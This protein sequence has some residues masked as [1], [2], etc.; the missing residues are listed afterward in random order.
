MFVC[1]VR[2]SFRASI[3][4]IGRFSEKQVPI[5]PSPA[6]MAAE[7]KNDRER[8]LDALTSSYSCVSLLK[9]SSHLHA[10]NIS[11]E[12]LTIEFRTS[13]KTKVELIA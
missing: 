3:T 1:F 9:R 11:I 7:V 10:P 2:G 4:E 5:M 6:F 12:K 8:P 13:S